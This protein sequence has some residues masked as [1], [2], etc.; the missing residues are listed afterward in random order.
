MSE[1]LDRIPDNQVEEEQCSDQV[2]CG[3]ELLLQVWQGKSE[4]LD[5]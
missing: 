4:T 2:V 5:W 3:V 1:S